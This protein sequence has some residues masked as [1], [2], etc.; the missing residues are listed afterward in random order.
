MRGILLLF[1]II[2]GLFYIY[3]NT[4]ATLLSLLF[5][6]SCLSA[7]TH[8]ESPELIAR[9]SLALGLCFIF[10]ASFT[11]AMSEHNRQLYHVANHDALTEIRNRRGFLV[12]LEQ[13]LEQCQ[14]R[15]ID[16][17]LFFFDLDGFKQI[18][19]RYGHDVGDKVLVSFAKRLISSLR[20]SELIEANGSIENVGRLSGDEFVIA[21]VGRFNAQD[22]DNIS[23][24]ILQSIETPMVIDSIKLSL[25]ASI[26]VSLASEHNFDLEQ[27]LAVADRNMYQFKR[28]QSQPAPV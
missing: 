27:L 17:A 5:I 6:V 28:N 4:G 26:G 20:Q 12:W 13:A 14:S 1:P 23:K 19:D 2:N 21:L 7:A 11:Q 16:L 18:N 8:V 10:A 22:T 25:Q 15:R 24:R 9:A 3:K